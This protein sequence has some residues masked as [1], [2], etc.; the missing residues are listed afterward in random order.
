[1]TNFDISNITSMSGMFNECPE[2]IEIKGLN[3]FNTSKVIDMSGMFQRC[4]KLTN[5]DLTNF[6]TSNVTDM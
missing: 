5:L 3:K 1:M 2:L 6:D 4:S